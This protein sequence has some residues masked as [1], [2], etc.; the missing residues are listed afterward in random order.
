VC[1]SLVGA[2]GYIMLATT[3]GTG[4]RYA[5]TFLAAAGIFPCIANLL[6]WQMNN[7][8]NDTRR[9][10]GLVMLS[11]IGQCGPLVG[12]NIYPPESGPR[13]LKGHS[14]CAA[15]MFFVAILALSLRFLLAYENRKLDRQYGTVAEQKANAET[16]DD[17]DARSQG[18]ENYGPLYRFVL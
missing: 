11:L 10:I 7:Q 12:T 4:P 1:C 14:I 18:V 6:P 13:Y 8:G 2:I 17:S 9:G 15:F 5:G 16:S 3:Q